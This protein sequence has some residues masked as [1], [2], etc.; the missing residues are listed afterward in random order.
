MT[1]NEPKDTKFIRSLK[2]H[3][4]N[5]YKENIGYGK[6]KCAGKKKYGRAEMAIELYRL[7]EKEYPE[8]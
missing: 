5:E 7:L 3:L 1:K 2:A 6:K 4:A 8:L